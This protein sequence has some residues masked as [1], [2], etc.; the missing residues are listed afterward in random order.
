M[1]QPIPLQQVLRFLQ[2]L[3]FTSLITLELVWLA[4]RHVPQF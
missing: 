2:D 4:Q 1:M 3:F